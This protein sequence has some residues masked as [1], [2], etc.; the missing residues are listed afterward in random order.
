[1]Q[2]DR[3]NKYNVRKSTVRG[4]WSD[5]SWDPLYSPSGPIR[6]LW[7]SYLSPLL[8]YA[9]RISKPE[10]SAQVWV[11]ARK[12]EVRSVRM[13]GWEDDGTPGQI[14]DPAFDGDADSVARNGGAYAVENVDSG[15][16]FVH[17]NMDRLAWTW[18]IN[19]KCW[20]L[21]S[22]QIIPSFRYLMQLSFPQS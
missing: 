5:V 10:I 2:S 7:F 19:C 17:M 21:S 15:K 11:R 16:F 22:V 18:A 6:P 20:K 14:S 12:I 8:W 4:P 9:S 1:M 3:G 13:R